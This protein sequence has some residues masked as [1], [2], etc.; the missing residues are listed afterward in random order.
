MNAE[1]PVSPDESE[2]PESP[3]INLVSRIPAAWVAPALLAIVVIA[4]VLLQGGETEEPA[5]PTPSLS[6][7]EV[8]DCETIIASGYVQVPAS[9]PVTLTVAG[10]A[11]PV[12]PF[13]LDD[14]VWSYPSEYSGHAAWLCG[15]VVNYV[16][17][18][19][20]T[21]DNLRLLDSLSAGDLIELGLANGIT[22]LFRYDDDSQELAANDLA[23]LE[24]SEPAITLVAEL[25]DGSLRVVTAGY[26]TSSEPLGPIDAGEPVGLES[27]AQVGDL[28]VT[29][30]AGHTLRGIPSLLPGTMYYLVE[31]E[32]ENLGQVPAETSLFNMVLQDGIGSTYLLSP[33][34][35]MSGD[36]GPF[37]GTIPPGGSVD[38]TAGY[39]VPET[40]K[41][42]TLLWRFS[43]T[44]TSSDVLWVSIPFE[45]EPVEPGSV[46][47]TI[48][49]AFLSTDGEQLVIV[50]EIRNST[51]D[52]LRVAATDI[53]LSSS[54]GMGSLRMA[55]PLLPWTVEPGQTKVIELQYDTPAASSA[56]LTIL[57]FSYEIGG[58]PAQSGYGGAYSD[59]AQCRWSPAAGG[60]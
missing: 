30:F 10:D 58:L 29:V 3:L 1:Q 12:L 18:L 55:A 4:V 8:V 50:G 6:P 31:V 33:P 32:V 38:G 45:P 26:E 49:D 28:Q 17:G 44:P 19:E 41:G 47:V 54:A 43:P 59:G 2:R 21:E 5:T 27:A 35:S 23:M 25:E 22:F 46:S 9:L 11:V 13:S 39:L 16:V 48:T 40:M 34:A 14:E 7:L 53:R 20:A 57:G 36:F 15:T 60:A 56:L 52:E 24:Q 37:E 51:A 42:P